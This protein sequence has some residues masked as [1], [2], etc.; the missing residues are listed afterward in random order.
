MEK[1]RNLLCVLTIPP[2]VTPYYLF[3]WR[4]RE[5]SYT[6]QCEYMGGYI[7]L[8]KA[9]RTIADESKVGV[10]I[11]PAFPVTAPLDDDMWAHPVQT[12]STS[13]SQTPQASRW[14][15]F[16]QLFCNKRV[17]PLRTTHDPLKPILAVIKGSRFMN[18]YQFSSDFR[19]NVTD[20]IGN[21]KICNHQLHYL[22]YTYELPRMRTLTLTLTDPALQ[23]T[24]KHPTWNRET[25]PP[26][27]IYRGAGRCNQ[28]TFYNFRFEFEEREVQY[29]EKV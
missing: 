8:L 12:T 25:V 28:A 23:L 27:A 19:S 11:K 17:L 20:N 24:S 16:Q 14:T 22:I 9:D 5:G 26:Y 10:E 18:R 21:L 7:P 6:L 13:S 1:N 15:L 29:V 2:F 3:D 4:K